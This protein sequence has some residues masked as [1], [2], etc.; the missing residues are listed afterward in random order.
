M[1]YLI[2]LISGVLSSLPLLFDFL[3]PLSWISMAPMFYVLI[4]K[5]P[6]YRYGLIW[7]I[8]YYGVLYY[9]FT[10]LYPMD[11]AG[12]DNMQSVAVIALAWIGLS[13]LQSAG[14]ALIAPLFGLT[15]GVHMLVYPFTL[16]GAWTLL[17]WLQTQ[18]WLGVPFMRMALSQCSFLPMIQSASLLGSLFTG[19]LIALVNGFFAVAYIGFKKQKRI[20]RYV[21][22][23]LS[24]MLL[25][26]AFG[27]FRL[28]IYTDTGEPV[29]VSLIQGNIASG[30]KWRDNSVYD[31]AALYDKLTREAS[32]Y[33]PDIVLW[34]E[35]VINV[36]LK[37]NP[38]LID[39]ISK[40]AVET[41]AVILTGTF[42]RLLNDE[43]GEAESYN[44]ICVFYSDGSMGDVSYYKRHPVPF[45]EYL[46]MADIIEIVLP[47]LAGMNV[48]SSDITAGTDSAL[49]ET[50]FGKI[51]GLV[52]FD[53]I[54]ETLT[55]E[56]VRDGAQLIALVT[57]DSWYRDSAAVYQHN[58]HAQLRAVETGRYIARAANT[59]ISSIIKPTGEITAS[60]QP[61]ESGYIPGE[62]YFYDNLTPY[63]RTGNIIVFISGIIC[64]GG[65]IIK[66]RDK[67]RL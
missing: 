66:Y 7:G 24:I 42:D 25:N 53:S 54:Y 26:F 9:W 22:C 1:M 45:G 15:K 60:L 4:Q 40:T 36:T 3:F 34:P 35:T 59:G 41:E 33:N 13:L 6:L 47:V 67:S 39:L 62:V 44:A 2:C 46:P 64:V 32:E 10:C 19:F 38:V 37:S 12:F 18:T 30:E 50:E 17:E 43:T 28:G 31:S 51:G 61:L 58:K 29:R 8:G 14:T 27:I 11:F 52:C 48:F 20:N 23:A 49:I 55:I 16:A 5:K 63:M 65:M 21:V 56:S 57:N